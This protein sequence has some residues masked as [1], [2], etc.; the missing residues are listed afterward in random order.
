MHM[1][2]GFGENKIEFSKV[3]DKGDIIGVNSHMH[4]F[5]AMNRPQIHDR[6]ILMENMSDLKARGNEH[7]DKTDYYGDTNNENQSSFQRINKQIM[8]YIKKSKE[9]TKNKKNLFLLLNKDKFG[10]NNLCLKNNRIESNCIKD[11]KVKHNPLAPPFKDMKLLY[12]DGV[13]ES[14]RTEKENVDINHHNYELYGRSSMYKD[15]SDRFDSNYTKSISSRSDQFDLSGQKTPSLEYNQN[16][17]SQ[18]FNEDKSETNKMQEDIELFMYFIKD[19]NKD[20]YNEDDVGKKD[21]ERPMYY[22]YKRDDI[23]DTLCLISE[24]SAFGSDGNEQFSCS[25]CNM[26]YTYRRCLMNHIK[27]K[28]RNSIK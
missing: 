28:H 9:N 26:K 23:H 21:Q 13:T 2:E 3:G 27:K 16:V 12:P 19:I 10:N 5:N 11:M 14:K 17:H 20:A 24:S 4:G 8:N 22:K 25:F 7:S 1:F 15:R 18:T 6:R